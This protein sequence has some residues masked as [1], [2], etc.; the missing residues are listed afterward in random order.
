VLKQPSCWRSIKSKSHQNPLPSVVGFNYGFAMDRI[1]DTAKR[2]VT[3]GRP[4]HRPDRNIWAGLTYDDAT[5]VRKWLVALGF[6]PG[7]VIPGEGKDEIHHSEM[8][9]P[10]GGRVMVSSRGTRPAAS[11]A[12]RGSSVLYVVT[13]DP[14]AIYARALT[15]GAVVER[16]L[17]DQTDYESRDFTIR[18]GEGNQWSFGTYAG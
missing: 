14:D 10:E 15:L 17:C 13:A 18:D 9:W 3:A 1:E 7:L 16:E 2:D 5:A 11:E 6:T 12:P 4:D 8:L